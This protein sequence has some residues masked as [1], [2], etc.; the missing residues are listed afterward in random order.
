VVVQ[1]RVNGRA[2]SSRRHGLMTV[3]AREAGVSVPTVSKVVNKK[4]G[5]GPDTR[6]RIEVLLSAHGFLRPEDARPQQ[7]YVIFRDLAGPY[8]LE[9]ARGVVDAASAVGI[10]CVTGT[11][12]ARPV[13]AW[14]DAAESAGAVGV[15]LVISM[16]TESDQ[17]RVMSGGVPVVLLDPLNEP[18]HR[19]PSI[20]VTNWRGARAAVEHL[21]A[22]GH[23][24]IGMVAGR[25]SS[26]AGAARLH[27]FRAALSEAGLP[28]DASLIKATDFDYSEG[29]RAACTL[30]SLPEPPTAIF[31]ASDS[32]A[33]GVLEAA[34]REGFAV[35]GQLSVVSFDDTAVAATASPPLTA[36]RQPFEE[37]GRVATR[38]LLDVAAGHQPTVTR[39]ELATALTVRESTAPPAAS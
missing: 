2:A 14:L 39:M 6:E 23:T 27:G 37:L 5:V 3:V 15:I 11:T 9:V 22:L 18:D 38:T 13:G 17:R 1:E 31:A 30:L 19:I 10:D 29:V 33:L 24:R 26:P 34:R 4:P 20:G 36:V 32:Q 7:V 35:P 21:L 8:T 12:S 28:D 25:P 16:L